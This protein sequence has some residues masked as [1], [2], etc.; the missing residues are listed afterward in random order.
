MPAAAP[1]G[2]AAAPSGP[3]AGEDPAATAQL[4]EELTV[5][6]RRVTGELPG[7]AEPRPGQESLAQAVG[8]AV[9]RRRHL[10]AQAGTGTGK[11]LAYLVGSLPAPAPVVVATATLALQDQLRTVDLPH[12]ARALANPDIP[13]RF[14]RRRLRLAVV[15]GRSNYLCRQRA[16]E[17]LGYGSWPELETA[18]ALAD[19]TIRP[20]PAA[21]PLTP[22]LARLL[23]WAASSTD[24]DRSSLAEEPDPGDWAA[25]SIEQHACPGG[26][27]CPSGASCF[28]ELARLRAQSA[29]VVVVNHALYANHLAGA[30]L[31]PEH[32]LVVLDEAHEFEEAARQA[33]GRQ[34]SPA[35]LRQVAG[36][37]GR[38]EPAAGDLEA[39]ARAL[40][41]V[42]AAR[43]GQLLDGPAHEA[44]AEPLARAQRAAASLAER[45]RS[46]AE[47]D[48]NPAA[49]LRAATAAARLAADLA[50]L[51]DPEADLVRW[52]SGGRSPSL[53]ASPLDLA[54][55]LANRLWNRVLGVLT[56]AT[57]PS[58]LA[59]RLGLPPEQTDQLSVPSPFDY[60]RQ[61]LL[62]VATDLPDRR[63]PE[64]D[65]QALARLVELMEAAGGRTLA[66]FTSWRALQEAH[67]WLSPRLPWSLLVQGQLPKAELLRR[68]A[69]DETS[70]LLATVSYWQG[71]DV[72]GRAVSLVVLDRIPFPRPDEPV[73]AALRARAGPQ[74]FRRVDLPRAATLLA[75]GCGRLIRRASD[76]G[77]VAVLD[78][79]LA[80]ASYRRVLLDALPPLRRTTDL[81]ETLAFLRHAVAEQPSAEQ[82]PAEQPPSEPSSF[83]QHSPAALGGPAGAEPGGPRPTAQE[84]RGSV[85]RAPRRPGDQQRRSPGAQETSSG[86]AQGAQ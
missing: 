1:S 9:V 67:A 41:A 22:A 79:R 32:A 57:L 55:L 70:C 31:L 3:A 15:K 6:L 27:A 56:S 59:E 16:A 12:L 48:R 78:P 58:D 18:G 60:R 82:P 77:V 7:G 5:T 28:A 76:R 74:G 64:A 83:E 21:P 61:A 13:E 20:G 69:E 50:A 66:L 49:R 38:D 73:L 19:G 10:L 35:R 11:T 46:Q 45:A 14:R 36:G 25:L 65:A 4:L 17:R 81:A 30:G 52:A 39:A 8:Q 80:T 23:S 43:P 86:G 62:Y 2:P 34:I 29:D 75:Q 54:P 42:L 37:A 68:F 84:P 85:S 47:T 33:L 72:P 24:G 51:V 53:Q 44:L 26:F 63:R 71:V 40:E